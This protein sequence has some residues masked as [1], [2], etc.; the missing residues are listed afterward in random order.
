MRDDEGSRQEA[1]RLYAGAPG[2]LAFKQLR[3]E[4]AAY[5]AKQ[6]ALDKAYFKVHHK[7]RKHTGSAPRL[8][9]H[10]TVI[11]TPLG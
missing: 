11:I 5:A 3:A 1:H 4:D 8:Q 7:K 9:F 6:A 2:R 10:V